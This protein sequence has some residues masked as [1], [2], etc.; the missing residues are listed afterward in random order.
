VGEARG[1]IP[2][3]SAVSSPRRF[4]NRRCG[5]V[6]A[7]LEGGAWEM[8]L[9]RVQVALGQP[10][11]A[12]KGRMR[13]RKRPTTGHVARGGHP[14]RTPKPDRCP[15][16]YTRVNQLVIKRLV[17]V[18]ERVVAGLAPTPAEG[19]R[20]EGQSSISQSSSD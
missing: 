12:G 5:Y 20:G 7:D 3:V 6:T 4:R 8:S 13:C 11:G 14:A 17:S 9:D 15:S 16:A 10:P 18:S 1:P 19:A 2:V